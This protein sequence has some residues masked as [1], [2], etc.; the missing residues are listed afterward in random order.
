MENSPEKNINVTDVLLEAGARRV[1]E[2]REPQ[3]REEMNTTQNKW[4]ELLN[5]HYSA[6]LQTRGIDTRRLHPLEADVAQTAHIIEVLDREMQHYLKRYGEM[7]ETL[8]EHE[9]LPKLAADR[10]RD[11]VSQSE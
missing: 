6:M 1:A 2:I 7:L 3:L 10:F 9:F 11:R 4:F 5:E 8:G